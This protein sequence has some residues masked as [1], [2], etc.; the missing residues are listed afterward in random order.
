MSDNRSVM[1]CLYSLVE[2]GLV[3]ESAGGK[4]K[5]QWVRA[6]KSEGEQIRQESLT[7]GEMGEVTVQQLM[8][9]PSHQAGL[10]LS[11]A[12][13]PIVDAVTGKPATPV[14]FD[15][16]DSEISMAHFSTLAAQLRAMATELD[17]TAIAL[18]LRVKQSE[19]AMAQM[20]RLKALLKG[21]E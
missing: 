8:T 2:A 4:F 11:L 12:D 14:R 17:A 5:R 16:A 1:G 18:A 21:F 15:Q 20:S 10:V 6:Q 19:E 13:C 3:V 9:A 7:A